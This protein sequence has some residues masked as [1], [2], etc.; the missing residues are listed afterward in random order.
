MGEIVG[1]IDVAQ[2]V[3]YV[4]WLFFAGLILYLRREDR[5]EGY[6][7]VNEA[8]GMAENPGAEFM[9]EPKTFYLPHGGM[10]M[11]PNVKRDDRETIRATPV[12][13]WVGAPL[14][15][16]G[17]PMLAGV[18]PGA[19]AQRADTP[20]LTLHGLHKIV[21]LRLARDYSLDP[22]DADPRGMIV[23]GADHRTAGKVIDVWVDQ[24]EVIARYLEVE[25]AGATPRRVLLPVPFADID[26]SKRVVHVQAVM[27]RHFAEVPGLKSPDQITFLEEDRIS[28]YYGAGCLYATPLRSESVL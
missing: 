13:S 15:P 14:E 16:S 26:G 17:N 19:Y 25:V 21:P 18:G 10:V 4:F 11:A 20:D 12:A 22:G 2:V 28:A 1:S 6:P 9:P 24:T 23:V 7:L 3:L 8:T 5:R 27:A